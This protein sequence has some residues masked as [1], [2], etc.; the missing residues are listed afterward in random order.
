MEGQFLTAQEL[1]SR[2]HVTRQH[3]ADMAKRG[4]MP[5]PF[6]F[7]RCTRWDAA[8]IERWLEWLQAQEEGR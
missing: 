2:L 4:Q 5:R 1:A 6:R 7:G 8:Q 3:V